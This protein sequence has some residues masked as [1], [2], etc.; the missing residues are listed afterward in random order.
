MKELSL[1]E[2]AFFL[3]N[4][5]LFSDLDLD[6]LIAIGEKMNQDIYEKNEKVFDRLQ[7][8]NKMYFIANGSIQIL[9]NSKSLIKTLKTNEFFGDESIFNEQPRSYFAIANDET[10]LLSINRTNL[11]TIISECPSIAVSLLNKYALN[12]KNR[13]FNEN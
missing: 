1:I 4:I 9:N 7:I 5:E 11:L 6:L 3:K 13:H 10:L 12:I 2:K 8:A